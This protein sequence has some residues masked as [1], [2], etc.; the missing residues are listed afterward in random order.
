[1]PRFQTPFGNASLRNSSFARLEARKTE[2]R[3]SA[4]P[5]GVWKR[6]TMIA[7]ASDKMCMASKP[8]EERIVM[9]VKTK[10]E[11]KIRQATADDIPELVRLNEAAYP[12]LAE[13]NIVWG[14]SHLRSHQRLFPQGQL[15]AEVGG[16]IV[17]A[18]ASLIVDMGRDS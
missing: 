5:N 17:G 4:F 14:Q 10:V 13:D 2:F 3:G 15:V 16:Q 8:P 1:S 9:T 18:C 11:V 6:E 12:T 7:A